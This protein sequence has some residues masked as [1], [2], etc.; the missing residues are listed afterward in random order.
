MCS[1]D[2]ALARV[3]VIS[4][5]GRVLADSAVSDSNL[6]AVENHLTRPEIQQAVAAGRGTDLRTSHTTGERTLYLAIPL[7][8]ANQAPPSVFLRL[9]LPMTTFEHE[10]DKL[11]RNLALAFG[12]T[13]WID[14]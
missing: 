5:D 1:S 13:F 6:P 3:T 12:I 11:H 8:S 10:A 2:L 7:H 9:G 4:P 14:L